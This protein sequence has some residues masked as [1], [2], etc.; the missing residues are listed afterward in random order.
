MGRSILLAAAFGIAGFT[1]LLTPADQLAAAMPWV[2]RVPS[3]ALHVAGA[4]DL[5]GALGLVLPAATR[6]RP[7]LTPLAALG[8]VVVMVL[9]AL[10]V[11]LPAG[12]W[13]SVGTNF[14]LGLVL[15][16]AAFGRL[17]AAP[18]EPRN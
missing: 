3:W 10:W 2:A 4:A 13:S 17:K 7:V 18:I 15:G 11:H 14:A 6:I 5:L 8:L 16:F 12:E 9:A 1:K